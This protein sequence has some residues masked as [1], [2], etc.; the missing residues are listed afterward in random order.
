MER[1]VEFFLVALN[2]LFA[3]KEGGVDGGKGVGVCEI[4]HT[5]GMDGGCFSGGGDRDGGGY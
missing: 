4:A 3:G 5:G 2:V 1:S